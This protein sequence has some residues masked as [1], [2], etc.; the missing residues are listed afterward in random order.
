MLEPMDDEELEKLR[1]EK[2]DELQDEGEEDARENRKKQVKQLAAQY[3]TKDAKS[4][5]GNI[6][7]ADPEKAHALETQIARL[8]QAGQ[9]DRVTDEQLKEILKSLQKDRKGKE[10][11][12][13]FRR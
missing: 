6:R 8:G 12:I 13:S 7:A 10:S 1:E 3:L 9:V 2:L 5:L 4:R 11:N